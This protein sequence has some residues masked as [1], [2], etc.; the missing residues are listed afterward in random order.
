MLAVF[1]VT[2]TDDS[3]NGSLREAVVSANLN[4]GADEIDIQTEGTLALT[5][6]EFG[7]TDS[8]T[9][10]GPGKD[11]FTIDAQQDSRIFRT[12]A[13]L[14]LTIRGLTL[15][16]GLTTGDGDAGRGGAIRS[17]YAGT[18][19]IEDSTI[20]G[21][22]TTGEDA[23]GGA[24]FAI[25]DV[26]I[27]NSTISNNSTA[28]IQAEGGG[29]ASNGRVSL[30]RSTVSGNSTANTHSDGGGIRSIGV[31]LHESSVTGNS[32]SGD[33]SSG[34]GIRSSGVSYFYGSTISG[35]FTSGENSNGG[36]I[37]TATL[38]SPYL[39]I[40]DSTIT[41][42]HTF[43]SNSIVGGASSD[44]MTITNS[45]VAGNTAMGGFPDIGILFGNQ[46][47]PVNYSLIGD[48]GGL[49]LIGVGNI[50]G[51][52]A[53]LG[54]L[55]LNGGITE[56]HALL[57]GSPAIDTG[58][59]TIAPN[60]A[61]FDQRGGPFLRV[62]NGAGGLRA[63]M[64]AYERQTVAGLNLEVSNRLDWVDGDTSPGQLS[65]REAIGLAN[66]SIGA[67]TITFDTDGAF[68]TVRT[69]LLQ[70]GQ[71]LEVTD[72]LTIEGSA[73][74]HVVIDA[75]QQSRIFYS[76]SPGVDFTI[77]GLTLSGG[78]TTAS[79]EEGD[80]GAIR[81]RYDGTL[82]IED[83]TITGNSTTNFFAR[84]GA[85]S[86]DGD[87]VLLRT[88]VSQNSTAGFTAFGGGVFT[89][90]N[91]L[92]TDSSITGN[93]TA[94]AQA[95]GGG[96]LVIGAITLINSTVAENSTNG[97]SALGGGI[98]SAGNITATGS[99]IRG[100]NTLG[101]FS[102]GGGIFGLG[103]VSI[104]GSAITGNGTAGSQSHGGG[105]YT[106]IQGVNL[107]DSTVSGN[108]TL[109]SMADGGGIHSSGDVMIVRSTLS[110]NAAAG[111]G[112]A[113]RSYSDTDLV[114]STVSGNRSFATIGD[115]GG[116]GLHI[117]SNAGTVTILLRSTIVEN[118][119]LGSGAKGG[120][121]SGD[122][123]DLVL[124]STILAG[125]IANNGGHDTSLSSIFSDYSLIGNGNGITII[126]TDN[127]IGSA[128]KL[129][130]LAYNGGPTQ[131]H[132]PLPDSLAIDNGDPTVV[133]IPSVS[134]QRGLPFTRVFGGRVDIGAVE[135]QSLV[136]F[137]LIVDSAADE[138]DGDYSAGDFSLREAIGLANGSIGAD[139]EIVFDEDVF[140]SPQTILLEA[141]ELAIIEPLI[142]NG[143][144]RTF[145][146]IDA[147][148]NSRIFNFTSATGF[149]DLFGLTLT[150]GRTTGN[151][152]GS[153]TT[154]NGGAIR[155]VSNG[156]TLSLTNVTVTSS[157]VSG[158]LASGG[159]IWAYGDVTLT[160]ST[161][162]GNSTTG[163][164]S[165]GGA[166]W[167]RAVTLTRSAVSG[168]TSV[169]AGAG[170]VSIG[171]AILIESTVSGNSV[172]GNA[173]GGGIR[174]YQ[175]VMLTRST[176]S[177]NTARGGA[178]ISTSDNVTAIDS[179]VSG[180]ES[181]GFSGAGG[182][183]FA[184]G[185]VLL[186][187][188]TVSGNSTVGASAPGGGVRASG[189]ITIRNST[190]T[191]NHANSNE[192]GGVW[193]GNSTVII[194]NSIIADNTSGGGSLPDISPGSGTFAVNYSLIG[195]T[196]LPGAGSG[197][198]LVSDSPLLGLLADNGGSTATHALLV[199]SPAIDNGDPNFDPDA[200]DP[201]L[202]NDQRGAP[203]AR[204]FGGRIDVGAFELQPE[205]VLTGD[206]NQ[207]GVVDAADY[208][209][210]RDTLG[211]TGL[212]PFSGAD[213]D[214][215]GTVDPDDYS[216]WK[217]H[218]GQSLLIAGLTH[219]VQESAITGQAASAATP[220]ARIPA[221]ETFLASSAVSTDAGERRD[222]TVSIDAVSR[223]R[224][225]E[226]PI[227]IASERA[228]PAS[229]QSVS[230]GFRVPARH[231]A[232]ARIHDDG[233]LAWL[234]TRSSKWDESDDAAPLRLP[235]DAPSRGSAAE[236]DVW[237]A[238]FASFANQLV[239]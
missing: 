66:G 47:L 168:N 68:N 73:E 150:N 130:P 31:T 226:S 140:S 219:A 128:A 58:D 35:N 194:S 206:Y 138:N 79:G 231:V 24:I 102:E 200:F 161:F 80:G 48:P 222:Q 191:D 77:S 30:T 32:T 210:W 170:I 71:S 214:G 196:V 55:A 220:A 190:I 41:D 123:N 118:Q 125:N 42:N 215:D 70:Y 57:P 17:L 21:N 225:G 208:T 74:Q 221:T 86:A 165:E 132:A 171:D 181:I 62:A 180:N 88:V 126:G 205:P 202:V 115:L 188:S 20:T 34:G 237:D 203:F 160:D 65:L 4:P 127:I 199:G 89:D 9:I 6:G 97:E 116:G 121:I 147:Q 209:V 52:S 43:G 112:G 13:A 100:N 201:P 50:T 137:D 69:I 167:G 67:D 54:P 56:T 236:G 83:S 207:N 189:N 99:T 2:N 85:I 149:F 134:D 90:A 22:A 183:I 114:E 12:T 151:N 63:D 108:S 122:N 104:I 26:E 37:L 1:S 93:S 234:T 145:L 18:L 175:N 136:G 154:F 5:F 230:A 135:R 233:L 204:V 163:S 87:I 224:A 29:I 155:S 91:A 192:G 148:Q 227:T 174:S 94:G 33:I 75:Q 84:G 76:S 144:G 81:S 78:R 46:N 40:R 182:G 11:L 28:G 235:D 10:N 103:F 179:T 53:N 156:G 105:I 139:D 166:V 59:P 187:G 238:T 158:S 195:T 178:G 239:R 152:A 107:T 129:G 217:A 61:V 3:G 213:G 39:H 146:T 176:V 157:T 38:G 64:G 216:V 117:S 197:N 218:F 142:I 23:D 119:A 82:T 113:L 44:Q 49:N 19:T 14:D 98:F 109:G 143:P 133:F 162:S 45:I 8:L 36:G 92:L 95:S 229:P 223:S 153:S 106:F 141:G 51:V 101:D 96:I 25:G 232:A 7:I 27:V 211:Q 72:T 15:T 60:N 212:T 169:G 131:T 184:S 185:E 193:N 228:A 159:A 172:T 177:G 110:G 198:N 164:S 111:V 16:G 186:I 173:S 124:H 120:G